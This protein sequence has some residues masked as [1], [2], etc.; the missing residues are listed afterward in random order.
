MTTITYNA[1][2]TYASNED[3]T[4]IIMEYHSGE[5][6]ILMGQVFSS[7]GYE[8]KE[9]NTSEDGTG[10][11]YQLFEEYEGTDDLTLYAIWQLSNAGQ[12]KIKNGGEE[13][14]I[15]NLLIGMTTYFGRNQPFP[16]TVLTM[17]K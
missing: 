4:P 15:S 12:V 3:N 11:T 16:Y 14:D 17:T 2:S 6:I 10:T 8:I 13:L 5:E 9:W 7:A 1:G